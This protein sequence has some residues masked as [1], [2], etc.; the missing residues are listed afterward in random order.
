[1]YQQLQQQPPGQPPSSSVGS[2]RQMG[3][4]ANSFMPMATPGSDTGGMHS[5]FNAFMPYAYYYNQM[6]TNF[7]SRSSHLSQ[8]SGS[9]TQSRLSQQTNKTTNTNHTN[10]TITSQPKKQQDTRL[11]SNFQ[12]LH[13]LNQ[14]QQPLL[15]LNQSMH[16]NMNR[17]QISQISAMSSCSSRGS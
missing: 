4:N 3:M 7:N 6:N 14:S 2:Q 13:T 17:S 1:M 10:F 9:D 11:S 12:Q 8:I 5:S 16:S 15:L